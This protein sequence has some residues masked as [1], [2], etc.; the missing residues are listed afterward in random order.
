MTRVNA[1]FAVLVALGLAGIACE[2]GQVLPPDEATAAAILTRQPVRTLGGGEGSQYSVGETIQFTGVSFLIPLRDRPG[3]ISASSHVSR[4]DTGTILEVASVNDIIWYRVDSQGGEGWVVSTD[5]KATT[6][7]AGSFAVGDEAYLVGRTFLINL[8]DSAG[9]SRF[10]AGQE[11]GVTVT[12]LETD[13]ID[14]TVWYRIKA[15][16]GEGWV[17]EENLSAEPPA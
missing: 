13:E 8:Y 15:P 7:V 12:V 17:P 1:I 3:E 14:G 5:V 9:S 11:R 4:G 2:T 16:T 10:I 6:G